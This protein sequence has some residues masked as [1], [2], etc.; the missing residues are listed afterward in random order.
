M[1]NCKITGAG[2][3][4]GLAV[5]TIIL[6]SGNVFAQV[7]APGFQ[8]Q[9]M[10]VATISDVAD[11]E[12]AIIKVAIQPGGASPLHTHP[13]DCYGAIL[14]GNVELVVEGETPK[15]FAEGQAWHN[16]RGP[17]HYFRNGG[18]KAVLM[19]N[20]LVVDKGKPRTETVKK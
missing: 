19:T 7:A 2:L 3:Y 16:P 11:K 18:D 4:G 12:V 20:I 14:Q 8:S 13:G 6:A 17:A 15:Q 9:P 1:K 10:L 5:M